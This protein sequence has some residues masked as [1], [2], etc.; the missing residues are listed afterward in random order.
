MRWLGS[1]KS[2]VVKAD[3]ILEKKFDVALPVEPFEEIEQ[4]PTEVEPIVESWA[5]DVTKWLSQGDAGQQAFLE[6]TAHIKWPSGASSW[7][8]KKIIEFLDKQH[9]RIM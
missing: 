3:A 6:Y 9:P 2:I 1:S 5:K 7:N 8:Q 4:L